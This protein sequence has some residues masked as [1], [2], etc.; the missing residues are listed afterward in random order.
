MSHPSLSATSAKVVAAALNINPVE[1]QS[2]DDAVR[3]ALPGLE[4]LAERNGFP[5][6]IRGIVV[7]DSDLTDAMSARTLDAVTGSGES[8]T[9]EVWSDAQGAV[10]LPTKSGGDRFRQRGDDY[11]ANTGSIGYLVLVKPRSKGTKS[12]A[13]VAPA[14]RGGAPTT[15]AKRGK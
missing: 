15:S 8:V 1:L 6:M 2:I 3:E 4:W 9:R 12:V 14:V 7:A 10:A 13:P 11:S 5:A